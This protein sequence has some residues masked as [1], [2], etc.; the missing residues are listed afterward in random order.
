MSSSGLSFLICKT[1]A[2]I[3]KLSSELQDVF[4]NLIPSNSFLISQ[5]GCQVSVTLTGVCAPH[6]DTRRG[7]AS[8]DSTSVSPRPRLPPAAAPPPACRGPASSPPRLRLPPARLFPE[9]GPPR[10]HAEPPPAPPPPRSRVPQP[11]PP[12]APARRRRPAPP[13][14]PPRSLAG[15]VRAPGSRR[16]R[17]PPGPSPPLRPGSGLRPR[18]GPRP[19]PEPLA[20]SGDE[21]SLRSAGCAA[22]RQRGG[23]QESLSEAS[24]EMAPG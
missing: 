12:F 21:V 20:L 13:S 16:R 8:R 19:R 24:P 3:E 15:P 17:G 2:Q 1:V 18:P 6:N 5:V 14:L 22:R 23:A 4:Q 9:K 10:V 11:A 7:P